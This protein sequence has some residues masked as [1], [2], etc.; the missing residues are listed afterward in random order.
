VRGHD[1]VS[2]L[3]SKAPLWDIVAANWP[4]AEIVW[5]MRNAEELRP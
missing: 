5:L 3:M 2:R 4:P 1:V